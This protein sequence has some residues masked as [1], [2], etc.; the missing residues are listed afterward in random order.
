M[1]RN[2]VK[3][4]Q[5]SEYWLFF[6]EICPQAHHPLVVRHKRDKKVLLDL[7]KVE[8]HVARILGVLDWF[9]QYIYL[10]I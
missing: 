8:N 3:Y 6:I 1:L 5:N 9:I 2:S 4:G 7:S 10:F